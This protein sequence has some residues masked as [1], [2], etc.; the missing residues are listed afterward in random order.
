MVNI[1]DLA[2]GSF[3][4]LDIILTILLIIMLVLFNSE[5]NETLLQSLN[6]LTVSQ[7]SIGEL[8]AKPIKDD[9]CP[10]QAMASCSMLEARHG[11]CGGDSCCTPMNRSK[12]YSGSGCIPRACADEFGGCLN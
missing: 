8:N 2:W 4:V 11:L 3:C 9:S 10:A 12:D 7:S 6:S 1:T 5:K